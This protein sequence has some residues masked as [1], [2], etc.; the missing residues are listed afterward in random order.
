VLAGG[1]ALR[2]QASY[3]MVP[4]FQLVDRKFVLRWD[5]TG[6]NPRHDLYRELLPEIPK[7]L[8]EG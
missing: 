6:H 2:N 8:R 7:L 4:G 3:V 1:P 5:A